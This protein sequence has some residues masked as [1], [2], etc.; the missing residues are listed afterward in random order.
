[1]AVAD[2]SRMDL[3]LLVAFDALMA[4]CSV[5]KA[6]QRLSIG[7]PAMSATLLR[8]RRQFDD[9]LLVR[10]GR[11]MQPTPLAESMIE[12]VRRAL[13]ILEQ[14]VDATSSFD[15]ASDHRTFSII[16][17]DYVTMVFLRPLLTRLTTTAPNVRIHLHPVLTGSVEQLRTGHSDLLI[18][19]AELA[20]EKRSLQTAPLFSDRYICA[21]GADN[22]DV[23]EQLSLAQ[24]RTQPYLASHSGPLQST[25]DEQL[26][27]LGI[28]RQLEVSTRTFLLA[29]FLLPGSR[30][31]AM[32]HERL[33][34]L[35]RDDF[36]L[37]IRLLEPPMALQPIHEVMAWTDRQS[38]DAAHGWL[39]AQMHALAAEM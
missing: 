7:Q 5:T 14:A 1:M 31:I 11:T 16:A 37:P 35:M 36:G 2:L 33:G 4:E 26:D 27:M 24:F 21:V 32:V 18:V 15:P 3:N 10:V 29:P 8:L 34:Q 23:G 20:G 17:S 6:A 22:T 25:A 13:A 28:G 19:P 12:P 9:P 39:R 38:H 30:L